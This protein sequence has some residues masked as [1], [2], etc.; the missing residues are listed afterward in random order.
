MSMV[1]SLSIPQRMCVKVHDQNYRLKNGI[2]KGLS[3]SV[4]LGQDV[5]I[6]IEI[7]QSTRPVSMVAN[8]A[9]TKRVLGDESYTFRCHAF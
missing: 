8:R 2:V 3:H 5:T 1:M 9:Q 4:V 7:V 6:L